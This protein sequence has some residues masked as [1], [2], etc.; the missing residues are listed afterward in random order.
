MP[1]ITSKDLERFKKQIILKNVGLHGQEKILKAK[2]LVIGAGGLGCPLLIYL[3]NSGVGNIGI[4]DNDKIE[5][6]NLNRQ[7][8]FQHKDI[9]KYKV[10][11][12]KKYV[13]KLNKK[14]KVSSFK[15]KLTKK[16]IEKIFNK[17]DIICDGT[18][19]FDSRFLINDF[20]KNKK[21][22]LISSAISK[23]DGHLFKFNFRKKSPCFRC[24]MPEVPD[25]NNNCDADGVMPSLAGIM[26]SLQANEVIKSII[27]KKENF[28]GNMLIVDALSLKFRKVKIL[29]NNKCINRC[30]N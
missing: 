25:F 8:I 5:L 21:K 13:K 15:E 14:I 18:D 24:Y 10:E 17:F 12:V 27:S 19:N 30:S 6:S 28:S 3:A 11:E 26:G 29:R 16:N 4:I 23:F 2:V 20:C 7:I 22:I 1:K 9:G